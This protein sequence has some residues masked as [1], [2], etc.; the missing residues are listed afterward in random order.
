ML[1][2]I[3]L[4][5][6]LQLVHGLAPLIALLIDFPFREN[7]D[8]EPL[9]QRIDDRSTDAVQTAGYFI[10][11]AAELAARM[12]DRKDDLDRRNS[13][14]MINA[15]GDSAPV[16]NNCNGI[17]FVDRHLNVIAESRKCLVD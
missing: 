16:V 12:K 17:I 11:S 7:A 5:D 3:A 8:L 15:D 2:R 4:A 6:D 14:L 13:G 10:S 9:R 1:F